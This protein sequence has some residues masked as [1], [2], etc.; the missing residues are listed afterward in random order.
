MENSTQIDVP[1]DDMIQILVSGKKKL[2]AGEANTLHEIKTAVG[3]I[4][5]DT[6]AELLSKKVREIE[7][8]HQYSEEVQSI[9]AEPDASHDEQIQENID[10]E[11]AQIG[12]NQE[13]E[14]FRLLQAQ[15]QAEDE[16]ARR[17]EEAKKK[18]AAELKRQEMER[19]AINISLRR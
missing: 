16:E 5:G 11:E 9:L 15:Q 14:N 1:V 7:N 3:V 18:R 2:S 12:N 8:Y 17:K 13:L 4:G 10:P 6:F 19:N